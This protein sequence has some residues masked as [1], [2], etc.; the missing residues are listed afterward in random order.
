MHAYVFAGGPGKTSMKRVL[1]SSNVL[2]FHLDPALCLRQLGFDVDMGEG[3]IR[4]PIDRWEAL[5]SKT[6]AILS[7]RGRRMHVR[8][9]SSLTGTTISL[10]LV[11]GP[12]TQLY[13]RPMYALINFVF[14][15]NC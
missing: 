6:Y 12:V 4:A 1:L 15:L 8:K 5:Q 9:L 14:F 11:W 10:K 3:K 13:T 2:K 7:A